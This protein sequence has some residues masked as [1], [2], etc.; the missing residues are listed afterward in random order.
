[1][2]AL[3]AILPLLLG[4]GAATGLG[5]GMSALGKR[6]ERKR[7]AAENAATVQTAQQ[8]AAPVQQP[9]VLPPEQQAWQ[10]LFQNP[11]G[12]GAGPSEAGAGAGIMG[13]PPPM[14]PILPMKTITPEKAITWHVSK[15]GKLS[16]DVALDADALRGKRDADWMGV[17][18]NAL[19]NAPQSIAEKDRI[20]YAIEAAGQMGYLPPNNRWVKYYETSPEVMSNMA[21]AA[22]MRELAT[23]TPYEV[24]REAVDGAYKVSPEQWN[25]ILQDAYDLLRLSHVIVS[26]QEGYGLDYPVEDRN[27][28]IYQKAAS[29]ASTML[30]GWTPPKER[31]LGIVPPPEYTGRMKVGDLKGDALTAAQAAGYGTNDYIEAPS[32]K[33]AMDSYRETLLQEGIRGKAE[34]CVAGKAK[35]MEITLSD[36]EFFGGELLNMSTQINREEGFW[37]MWEGVKTRGAAWWQGSEY[38]AAAA[39]F[40]DTRKSYLARFARAFGEVGVL[41]ELD[42]KRA[43]GMLP[44]IYDSAALAARKMTRLAKFVAMKQRQVGDES[45][46]LKNKPKLLT[47]DQAD[48]VA[49]RIGAAYS[50]EA[51]REALD[52]AKAQGVDVSGIEE[53][54]LQGLPE[55]LL[56]LFSPGA[57]PQEAK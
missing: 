54:T 32:L 10:I 44:T 29:E 28:V 8:I 31:Q 48:A 40:M 52:E 45:W 24:A 12:V 46:R 49:E 21:R 15:G 19:K 1:M 42:I 38:G 26:Q 14:P 16:A 37:R 23:G 20:Q 6:A 11:A 51:V 25:V 27:R 7:T 3:Y 5:A 57:Q 22:F 9:E 4:M 13:A 47:A 43:E 34:V 2:I 18:S 41:T 36:L 35:E 56:D 30:N 39:D 55:N 50:K 53:S 33:T 17:F